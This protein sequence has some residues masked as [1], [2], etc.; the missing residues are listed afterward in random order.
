MIK[1]HTLR[2]MFLGVILSI[3]VVCLV[4][5]IYRNEAVSDAY[6]A[7]VIIT[8]LVKAYSCPSMDRLHVHEIIPDIERVPASIEPTQVEPARELPKRRGL[9]L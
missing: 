7:R 2:G 3:V 5:W 8:S 6:A 4:Q 9:D 1:F